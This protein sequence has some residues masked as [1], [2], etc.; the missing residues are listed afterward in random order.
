M[1]STFMGLETGRR[2]LTTSQW[3][4]QATGNNVSNAGTAGFSRQR[5]VQATTEQLSVSLGGGKNVQF[6]TGVRG[7]LVERLRDVMVDKQYRDE[8]TKY[9]YYSTKAAAFGR[10]EDIINEPSETG[11][12]KTLD[13]FWASL[14]GLSKNP[15]DSGARSVV[16]QQ[17][18]TVSKTFNYLATS[19][20]KVQ[21]DLKN[22]LDVSTKKVNDLLQK[23]YNVN[24][25][26]HE[27]E[28]IGVLPN[29]LYDERDRYFDELS[30][31][32]DFKKVPI[33]A[34]AITSG[35]M[36]N[37]SKIAEGRM[38]VEIIVPGGSSLHAV[39]MSITQ[40]RSLTFT[41]DPTT[42]AITGY[43]TTTG[44]VLFTASNSFSNGKLWALLQ[45][46]GYQRDGETTLTGEYPKMLDNLDKMAAAF[47]KEFNDAH[48]KNF[49]KSKDASGTVSNTYGT[50]EFFVASDGGTVKAGTISVGDTIWKDLSNIMSSRDGNIGDG[51]GALIL[52]N[53]KTT[54]LSDLSA[55]I[56]SFYQSIIGDMGVAT[57]QTIDLGKNAS[58]LMENADQRRMS[59]SAVSLDEEMT[60][61]IQ[62]QHAYNAAARNITTVDEML[63]KIINGMGL[64]G[65]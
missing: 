53:I 21:G 13:S 41:E 5:L 45:M 47:A 7:E 50:N 56:G 10:M 25:Q 22:E 8:S 33:D 35:G 58:V 12:A 20:T 15:Q 2:A 52:A 40:A 30:T 14:Q 62:Y 48:S 19:L 29:D 61:M 60:M 32:V 43:N 9:A 57:S 17:A 49:I 64:V 3:A 54:S 24:T 44:P 28:P 59:V 37:A 23:I 26:I 36:G 46:H 38:D 55:P 6:G 65:R 42:K 18:D 34:T 27:I 51:S 11:L 39:D 1:G 4:L 16:R 31:Y 63:D